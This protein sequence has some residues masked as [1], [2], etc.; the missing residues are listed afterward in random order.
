MNDTRDT[1]IHNMPDLPRVLADNEFGDNIPE[2]TRPP[3][4]FKVGDL[5]LHPGQE[6]PFTLTREPFWDRE[7]GGWML[8]PGMCGVHESNYILAEEADNWTPHLDGLWS[9]WE[10]K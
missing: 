3:C 4:R 2:S 10:R 1:L 8:A 9:W 6:E 7:F 5:L